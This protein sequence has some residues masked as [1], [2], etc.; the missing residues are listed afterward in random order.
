MGNPVFASTD[1]FITL[2]FRYESR[3]LCFRECAK[4]AVE[5]LLVVSAEG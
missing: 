3:F 4:T 2:Q 1:V 5:T